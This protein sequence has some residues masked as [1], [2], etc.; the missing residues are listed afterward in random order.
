MAN[1]IYEGK[2]KKLF[3][4]DNPDHLIQYFKDD[5]TAFNAK[6]KGIIAEKGVINNSVSAI[7]FSILKEKGIPTHFIEKIS[8]REM[9][10]KR[11]SIIPV[12]VV[13]RNMIAGS[14]AKKFGLDE[15]G[16]LPIPVLEFYY[17]SDP[18]GDPMINEYH[19]KAMNLAEDRAIDS[20][21]AYSLMINEILSEFFAQRRLDLVD[22]KLEFGLHKNELMLGDEISP[23]TCRLWEKETGEK[24]DKDRFRRDLG[25]I[26][27]AYKE[28]LRRASA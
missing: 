22:I 5:A 1:M 24:M 4:T 14:L 20:I 6:K 18:L 9:L 19:I 7:L 27:E 13:V 28:V 8:D 23:D 12:E 17:K 16:R 10:V 21:K 15:G 3:A 25:R 2:A 26:E 11:L